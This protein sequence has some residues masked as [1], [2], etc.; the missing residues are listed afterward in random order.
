MYEIERLY[1]LC[2]KNKGAD[3]LLGNSAA[4]LHLCFSIYNMFSHNG[5]LERGCSYQ[6]RYVL[7]ESDKV[8]HH[9]NMSMQK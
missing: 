4:D 3:L 2:S 8:V 1:Y 6:K 5:Q 9:G 7:T